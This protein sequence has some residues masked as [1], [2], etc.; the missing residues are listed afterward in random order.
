MDTTVFQTVIAGVLTFVVGQ[1]VLKL[2][3]EPVHEMKKTIADIAHTLIERANVIANPGVPAKEVMEEASQELRKL[4]SRLES[5]L[6]LIPI[7]ECTSL[8]FFL[9]R[10]SK[11]LAARTDLIGLSN[12]VF[13]ASE[14]IY[15]ENA[16]RVE[17]ICDSLGI[18]LS[19]EDRWPK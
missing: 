13:R 12:G 3:I 16:R 8:L 18:Y 19:E 7:Y 4:S 5:H 14:G 1:L 15:R 11:V 9:P 17:N 2:L 6:Y 10:H